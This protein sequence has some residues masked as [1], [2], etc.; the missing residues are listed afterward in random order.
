M[1]LTETDILQAFETRI[2]DKEFMRDLVQQMIQLEDRQIAEEGKHR[3]Q[4]EETYAKVHADNLKAIE[5]RVDYCVDRKTLLS[6]FLARLNGEDID[7]P[8]QLV[9][10]P[11]ERVRPDMPKQNRFKGM[12]TPA[13]KKNGKARK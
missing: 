2:K 13:K 11:E 7:I 8:S 5:R 10:P 3:K 9:L 4:R 12:F 1:S 6:A